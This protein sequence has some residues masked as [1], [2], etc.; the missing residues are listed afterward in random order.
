MSSLSSAQIPPS[1]TQNYPKAE[2]WVNHRVHWFV[3]LLSMSLSFVVWCPVTQHPVIYFVHF[4]FV[5]L[6]R[7]V[8]RYLFHHV[9]K[10][11]S[12]IEFWEFFAYSGHRFFVKYL[13][14]KYIHPFYR[15]S[16]CFLNCAFWGENVF[17]FDVQQ[18]AIAKNSFPHPR[19]QVFSYAFAPF[20][21][22]SIMC[23]KKTYF[24]CFI[25]WYL[26][27]KQTSICVMSLGMLTHL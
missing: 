19:S 10:Q 23:V 4:T 15:L 5:V 22:I 11:L 8:K 17:N 1:S 25:V 26:S 7:M 12:I 21:S 6:V 18:G 13:I 20:H 27:Q 9:W 24:C 16:F 14:F 3:S 2:S